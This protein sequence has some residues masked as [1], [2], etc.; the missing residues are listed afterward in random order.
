MNSDKQRLYYPAADERRAHPERRIFVRF[1]VPAPR[2]HVDWYGG[3]VAIFAKRVAL[4]WPEGAPIPL[5]MQITTHLAGYSPDFGKNSEMIVWPEDLEGVRT[6]YT[7]LDGSEE[8]TVSWDVAPAVPVPGQDGV[9]VSEFAGRPVL[10]YRADKSMDLLNYFSGKTVTTIAGDKAPRLRVT[11]P[12]QDVVREV[13]EQVV[14][15]WRFGSGS[16]TQGDVA[17]DWPHL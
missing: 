7:V 3:K 12:R 9:F 8:V 15:S 11:L 13:R 17:V 10:R 5:P 4:W 6:P 2:Y 16:D 14:N 1:D